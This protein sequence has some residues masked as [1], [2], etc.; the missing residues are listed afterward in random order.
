MIFLAMDFIV[1][2]FNFSIFCVRVVPSVVELTNEILVNGLDN[3]V[4][5]VTSE[6]C[7]FDV[8]EK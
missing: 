6:N 4:L 1:T 3:E 8:G 5:L 2:L 7:D